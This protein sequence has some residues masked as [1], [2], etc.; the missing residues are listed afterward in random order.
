M[1]RALGGVAF[2]EEVVHEQLPAQRDV[3]D[4]RRVAEIRHRHR[5]AGLVFPLRR[6]DRWQDDAVVERLTGGLLRHHRRHRG[7][8][9]SAQQRGRGRAGSRGGRDL[10]RHLENRVGLRCGEAGDR[11]RG[12][13][14]LCHRSGSAR[15]GS[16]RGGG[17]EGIGIGC[18][19]AHESAGRNGQREPEPGNARCG[20]GS[21]WRRRSWSG[22]NR[23]GSRGRLAML[24]FRHGTIKPNCTRVAIRFSPEQAQMG[25]PLHPHGGVLG[26]GGARLAASS[27]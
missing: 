25:T 10:I 12:R 4:R 2:D 23:G 5:L 8:G 14:R 20:S 22:R 18:S 1:P 11:R 26:A 27:A 19:P 24:L 3:D 6:P 7:L 21:R 9:R 13:R 15:R 17:A 16:R